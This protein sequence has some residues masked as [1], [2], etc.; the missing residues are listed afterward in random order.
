LINVAPRFTHV[1]YPVSRHISSKGV[2]INIQSCF[3]TNRHLHFKLHHVFQLARSRRAFRLCGFASEHMHLK[4]HQRMY[5]QVSD[6]FEHCF[7]SDLCCITKS[8]TLWTKRLSEWVDEPL[9]EQESWRSKNFITEKG[10]Y[11]PRTVID[12]CFEVYIHQLLLKDTFQI[13]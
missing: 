11:Q 12:H 1:H 4:L 5:L 8:A 13:T 7:F 2:I 9:Y 6:P 3:L 10:I